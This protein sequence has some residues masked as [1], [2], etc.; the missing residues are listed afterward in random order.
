[1]REGISRLSRRGDEVEEERD[2]TEREAEA[3]GHYQSLLPLGRKV[4]LRPAEDPEED[5]GIYVPPLYRQ[6]YPQ[7][8]WVVACAQAVIDVKPGDLC[9]LDVES[10]DVARQY[11]QV[12]QI[13]F[14]DGDSDLF[15]REIE[16]TVKE[17]YEAYLA[18]K[19]KD[20]RI[21]C[22]TLDGEHMQ[23]LCSDILTFGLTSTSSSEFSFLYPLG[24]RMFELEGQLFYEAEEADILGVICL[25]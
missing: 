13:L 16:P 24:L 6:R 14:T 10:K 2:R 7:I 3:V 21:T 19:D 5:K 11:D 8:A 17:T 23:F 15:P 18:N 25:R 22:E 12:L 20:R 4:I 9:L 1:M